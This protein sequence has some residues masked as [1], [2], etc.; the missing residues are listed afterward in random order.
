MPDKLED[1]SVFVKS[2]VK[3]RQD[4]KLVID[5]NFGYFTDV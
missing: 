3:N 1:Y 4:D 2:T 5:D